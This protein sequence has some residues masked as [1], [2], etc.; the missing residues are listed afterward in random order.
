VQSS[1]SAA[2]LVAV[3]ILSSLTVVLGLHAILAEE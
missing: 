3:V 1:M 2:I